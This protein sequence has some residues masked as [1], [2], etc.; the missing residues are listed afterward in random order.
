MTPML[1]VRINAGTSVA[2]GLRRTV[3]KAAPRIVPSVIGRSGISPGFGGGVQ[4]GGDGGG[5]GAEYP[6]GPGGGAESPGA[7]AG[8]GRCAGGG[9]GT[10]GWPGACQCWSSVT[11]V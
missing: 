7:A 11:A 1:T 5:G 4:P 8:A 6:G 2:E 10:A 3:W 9:G